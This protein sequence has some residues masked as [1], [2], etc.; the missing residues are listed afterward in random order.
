MATQTKQLAMESDAS[1]AAASLEVDYDDVSLRLLAVRCAN[2]TAGTV[3][4]ALVQTSNGRLVDHTFPPGTTTITVPNTAAQR[5][6]FSAVV[7][8]R[9]D[10]VE[11]TFKVPGP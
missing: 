8:N 4:A 1:G 7:R 9:L 11:M 5:V 2:G 10:G 3:Y 6:F